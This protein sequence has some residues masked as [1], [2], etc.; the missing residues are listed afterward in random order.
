[1]ENALI[2]PE[3]GSTKGI[4][5]LPALLPSGA[6]LSVYVVGTDGRTRFW[7]TYTGSGEGTIG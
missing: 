7:K 1:V 5:I 3:C 2:K 6:R 4:P